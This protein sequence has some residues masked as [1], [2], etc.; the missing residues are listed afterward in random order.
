M[1]DHWLPALM[2]PALFL[3]VFL[4]I[5][6]AFSLIVIAMVFGY[7][8]FGDM[9]G[10]QAF[11]F[12]DSVASTYIL[13]AIPLFIFM[14]AMLERSGI[15][16]RLYRTMRLW[17]GGLPG[18]LG[19]A[20]IAMCAIFAA[21]TGIVGAVEALVGLM[22]IPAM[23]KMNYDKGLITGTICAGGS[24]GTIIPPSI[25]A[26]IYAN[27]AQISIGKA[28]AGIILPGLLM[29][30]L[31]LGYILI[32]CLIQPSAGPPISAD[33][34]GGR[35]P[36]RKLLVMTAEA[37]LPA[38]LLVLAVVGSILAGIASPTEAAGLGAVG[39]VVLA[40]AYRTFT[41][42]IL[43]EALKQTISIN[44]MIMLIVVGGTMFT[45]IFRANGGARMV[46][47][48]V[49]AIDPSPAGLIVLLLVI[50]FLLGCVLEWVSVVLICV[51]I[52]V[53]LLRMAGVD[54]LWF[55]I[56]MIVVI[57]TSYLTPPMAPAI[58]YLRAISPPEITYADMYR[59]VV[60][61]VI[62]QLV[63]LLAVALIPGL[64]TWLPEQLVGF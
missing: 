52:F 9:I 29:V 64:A 23:M 12:L 25:V 54:P 26:V 14:G 51:P 11:R 20:T 63:V 43:I 22:A 15:A 42:K 47:S 35:P 24:L 16:E 19:L 40:I 34:E 31:F 33:E 61:F 57:Q 58:F 56:M 30:L 28:M 6:V 46:E 48:L 32:R 5:P 8:F 4:G 50:V 39:T 59:G 18:G 60:P 10:V 49:G 3:L 62:C 37:L 41:F 38:L 2:F 7:A 1:L 55:G 36:M 45:S 17:L 27:A 13:A 44:A 21:G 53:P